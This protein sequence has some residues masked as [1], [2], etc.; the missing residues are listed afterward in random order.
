MN[1]STAPTVSL[2]ETTTVGA[3]I[4]CSLPGDGYD[5]WRPFNFRATFKV[6]DESEQQALDDQQL[7]TRD[8]LREVVTSVEGVPAAKDPKTGE[9]VSPLEVAIRNQFTQDAMWAEYHARLGKN[10]RD[11]VIRNADVKNS[12]RSRKR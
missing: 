4:Q 7:T 12:K 5:V 1:E 9:D 6:L 8:Y 10:S 11:V 3:N 2:L